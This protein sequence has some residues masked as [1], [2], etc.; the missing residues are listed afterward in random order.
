M[1][2]GRDEP[3]TRKVGG[4]SVARGHAHPS[5]S[6]R[7]RQV[8][9]C[10]LAVLAIVGAMIGSGAFGG[11]PI[12]KAAGGALSSDATLIAPAGSAFSIWSVIYA[13]LLCYA[14][15]Q[16]LPREATRLV[17]RRV[18]YAVA[19]SMILN[20]AWIG[21]VQGGMLTLSV[22]VIAALL[23]VLG[24]IFRQLQIIARGHVS[25]KEA[26]ILDGTM[27][28]YL[29]WVTI[30]TAANV[31]ALLVAVGFTGWGISPDIWGTAV[32]VVAAVI[33]V[34]TAV[35]GRG[36]LAP[37]AALIWGLVWLAVARLTGEP[38]SFTV[39]IAGIGAAVVIAV[40]VIAARL[41]AGARPN[42]HTG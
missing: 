21:V 11:T 35:A 20:A 4:S 16:A 33:G 25:V 18:G 10:V 26:V 22:I 12:Q 30:A 31:A 28:L 14:V 8:V 29:G 6:D 1:D 27:G 19:L 32:V 38:A 24:W 2:A 36:R 40:A 7:V 41:V 13:G 17:H 39:G 23:V 37:A 9:V 3:T 42:D 34:S 5:G 15:W